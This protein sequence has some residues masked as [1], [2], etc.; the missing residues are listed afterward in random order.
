MR[1]KNLI[2][3][4]RFSKEK[5]FIE[6]VNI[7]N[8][9]KVSRSDVRLHIIGDGTERNH[10]EQH[11]KELKSDDYI[12]LHGFRNR[13]YIS[14]WYQ[15]SNIYIMTSLEEALPFVLIE[16]QSYGLP[17]IAYDSARGAREIIENGVSG[18]LIKNRNRHEFV[19]KIYSLIDE[20]EI[21]ES[22]SNAALEN[23]KLYSKEK[24]T[25]KWLEII[26]CA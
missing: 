6:M 5:D 7:M 21:Y 24:I 4:G 23:A 22:M 13:E 26:N 9:I 18:F 19:E 11:I 25:K 20:F 17:C 16:A 15:K 3:V 8:E 12:T 10:I 1:I 2:A 14:Q